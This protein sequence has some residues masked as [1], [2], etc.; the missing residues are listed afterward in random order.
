MAESRSNPLLPLGFLTL[1][2][3]AVCSS[4]G[5]SNAPRYPIPSPSAEM[6]NGPGVTIT[7]S[8]SDGKKEWIDRAVAAFHASNPT[9]RG[10]PVH[11]D[12]V[13]MRS[14]ESMRE[15][16]AGREQPTVW[17]PVSESWVRELNATWQLRNGKPLVGAQRPLVKSALVVA[18]WEPMARALGWPERPVGWEDIARVA[19]DPH[20]WAALGHPEWG[21][22]KFGHAHPDYSTSAML[23]VISE[24]YAAAGKR[25]G[26]TEADVARERVTRWVEA[27]ERSI[28]HY[29]KS[30][31]WLTE[32]LVSRGPGYLSGT[33]LYESSVVRANEKYPN[34]AFRV[35]AIYPK[36]GTFWETH[37]T[38]IVEADWVTADQAQ[39]A[40]L[41]VDHLASRPMQELAVQCGFRPAD[42]TVP[43]AAP[44]DVEHGVDP[45]QDGHDALAPVT[46]AVFRAANELW[47]HV[48]KKA[49]IAVVLD[50]SGSMN[51]APMDAAKRGVCEL[52]RHMEKQDH[53]QVVAFS[54]K[55]TK[56]AEGPV[57]QVGEAATQAVS[58]LFADGSTA[59]YDAVSESFE[60]V[61][62]EAKRDHGERLHAVVVL[63]DGKD[64][65][66]RSGRAALMA[67]MPQ[68]DE[69]ESTKVYTIAYG[70]DADRDLLREIAER[71][72]AAAFDGTTSNIREIYLDIAAYF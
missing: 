10:Q 4:I 36:E 1:C 17:S 8:S 53:I 49:S 24:V 66:S 14:G 7:L 19:L 38:G 42:P 69:S 45:K 20:G 18:L 11:V 48:K 72:N 37:P 23:S 25:E 41:L 15:I 43:L 30:S 39:A 57:S 12:V 50:V 60:Q 67:R 26:L 16:L 65:S 55:V 32:K 31:S 63:T 61:D 56:L 2:I 29:G 54:T 71:S 9:V 64:T 22:F 3:A 35:V 5:G 40:K 59:L 21:R 62:A 70:E 13:H 46:D 52:I 68:A 6:T 51:G 28:V 58:G 33:P 27:V 34:K 47:H 44:F